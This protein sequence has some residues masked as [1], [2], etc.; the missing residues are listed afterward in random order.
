M[1]FSFKSKYTTAEEA[2]KLINSGDRVY[3]H[4]V[5]AAPQP[6]I[7]A[8]T[9]RAPELDDVEVIH[10]HTEGE[11]PYAKPE[12]SDTFH[13][14]ALFVGANVRKAVNEGSADYL[15]I[16]LSEVPGLFRRGILPIDMAL[17]QVSPPDKH[18]Y[19]SL[20]V[21]VDAT[22]AALQSAE[23]AI[24]MVNPQMP[25][26]HGD[27]I[28]H[29]SRFNALVE[30][31]EPLHELTIPEPNEV[32]R[33]IGK[34]C[35][36][37][38]EDGATLQMGIGAIPNAVLQSLGNHKDLGIHTE[39]FS[40]GVIDL[41]DKGVIN[42][43]KKAKH[44]EKIVAGFVMGSRRLYDF[45]DDNPMISMLDIAYVNDTSV[46]RK[47]PKVTAINS[48]IEVD[49][50]GQVCADSI[51]TYH[52]SGVGGQMDFIRGASLSEGGKPVI[53]LTSVTGKGES[54]IVPNLKQGA[55]VV[56]TRA[57]VHYV[58]TEYGV[59]NLYG[60]NLRQRAKAMIE[61]AHPDHRETLEKAAMERF[62]NMG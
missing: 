59:A 31:D 60:R 10:L 42:G 47:N 4:S 51:G 3:I 25:R 55:G 44:P 20:G 27:G 14:N 2:V 8:M 23:K 48:A 29:A 53:A 37:L 32:E 35:A 34:N 45:V 40:D 9:A 5:A 22:R 6:L 62:R 50:T 43:K 38:I 39:M 21:S 1:S 28:F 52:Y 30:A 24:A 36:E 54:K 11:A 49:L 16:F 7:D 13:T 19:C 15:P 41:V 46:I 57:H 58:V 61:I 33:Q 56:T 26:T 12:Y 17:V 18:G